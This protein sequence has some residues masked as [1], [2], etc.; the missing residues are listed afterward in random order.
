MSPVAA[1]DQGLVQ[2]LV[3]PDQRVAVRRAHGGQSRV[4]P[5]VMLGPFLQERPLDH[6]GHLRGLD[7]LGD[8]EVDGNIQA[9][10]GQRR[11]GGLV[12]VPFVPPAGVVEHARE[13]VSGVAVVV[14]FGDELGA[15]GPGS[16]AA[17]RESLAWRHASAAAGRRGVGTALSAALRWAGVSGPVAAGEHRAQ[18]PGPVERGPERGD[19]GLAARVQVPAHV[20][21]RRVARGQP[22]CAASA[23]S[24]RATRCRAW[25]KVS[26]WP[27][28]SL[29]AW[30]NARGR[31]QRREVGPQPPDRIGDRAVQQFRAAGAGGPAREGRLPGG[32]VLARLGRDGGDRRVR[33]RVGGHLAGRPPEILPVGPLH[34]VGGVRERAAEPVEVGGRARVVAAEQRGEAGFGGGE[35]L[36][37]ALPGNGEG[38]L[39]DT[40][41]PWRPRPG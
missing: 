2:L 38:E 15:G 17:I 31:V 8:A 29:T 28:T 32:Q 4:G 41:F 7:V 18:A 34:G 37:G 19:V 14:E 11:A 12:G 33:Q 20:A 10:G 5:E 13:E 6:L 23:A 36:C 1:R 16:N 30:V 22:L 27:A 35:R 24:R 26:C 3:L 21:E 25:T 9:V 40:R 39:S